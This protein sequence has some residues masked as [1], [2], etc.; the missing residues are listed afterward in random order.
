MGGRG[1]M[2]EERGGAKEIEEKR[3]KKRG[4]GQ[5]CNDR[6]VGNHQTNI[7]EFN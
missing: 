1:E 6:N 7:N 4:N 3:K 5:R 2:G